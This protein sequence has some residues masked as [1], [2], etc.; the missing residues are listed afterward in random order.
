M[1]YLRSHRCSGN[2][3]ESASRQIIR[4][5]V[6]NVNSHATVLKS[7]GRPRTGRD[8]PKKS[9]F[10]GAKSTSNGGLLPLTSRRK[11][12][13]SSTAHRLSSVPIKTESRK[14]HGPVALTPERDGNRHSSQHNIQYQ[15]KEPV[16]W[17]M[18]LLTADQQ[19][20][21]RGKPAHSKSSTVSSASA[22]GA[23]QRSQP[24]MVETRAGVRLH[25]RPAAVNSIEAERA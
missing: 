18:N 6:D 14:E 16:S 9:L 7:L 19:R 21:Q 1:T 4:R 13:S 3:I 10:D 8:S 23:Q 11:Y 12:L 17:I 20:G 5:P 25:A 15:G 24:A 2:G 22:A